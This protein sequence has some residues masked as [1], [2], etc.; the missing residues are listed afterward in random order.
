MDTIF[1]FKA[2]KLLWHNL[3][4]IKRYKSK[5]DQT[6]IA[7]VKY[8]R[9]ILVTALSPISSLFLTSRA[10]FLSA[11]AMEHT[12]LSLSMR[13]NSTRMGKPFSLR[14]VARQYAANYRHIQIKMHSKAG[15]TFIKILITLMPYYIT[16]CIWMTICN[17]ARSPKFIYIIHTEYKSENVCPKKPHKYYMVYFTFIL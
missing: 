12:T 9:F 16:V 17:L 8:Y 6:Y 13:S 11:V 4:C 1:N 2:V 15:L 5:V 14:T 7:W 3:H 10:M